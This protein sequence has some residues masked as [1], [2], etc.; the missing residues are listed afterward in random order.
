MAA[1]LEVARRGDA[2]HRVGKAQVVRAGTA[3]APLEVAWRRHPQSE[4]RGS[5]R[6][7]DHGQLLEVAGRGVDVHPLGGGGGG[8]SSEDAD[9]VAMSPIC[10]MA[11][12]R[13][14]GW[15]RGVAMAACA[16]AIIL[17]LGVTPGTKRA[18]RD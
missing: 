4:V 11:L 12:I 8:D 9:L 6:G 13:D 7:A 16:P 17:G 15:P 5:V 10:E 1:P 18:G 3:A 14:L 2:D